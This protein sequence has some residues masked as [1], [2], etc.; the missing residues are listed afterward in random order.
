MAPGNPARAVQSRRARTGGPRCE[1]APTGVWL[2]LRDEPADS[3]VDVMTSDA[4]GAVR[5]AGLRRIPGDDLAVLPHTAISVQL[6][7]ELQKL[8]V[9]EGLPPQWVYG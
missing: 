1:R 8:E 5:Y 6:A 2:A 9:S 3:S 7:C 4:V